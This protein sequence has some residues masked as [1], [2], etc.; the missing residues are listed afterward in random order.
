MKMIIKKMIF[1]SDSSGAEAALRSDTVRDNL[2]D[3]AEDMKT[4]FDAIGY[5]DEAE[6]WEVEE[7]SRGDRIVFNVVNHDPAVKWREVAEGS[8]AKHAQSKNQ[9]GSSRGKSGKRV[10]RKK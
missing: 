5:V 1:K 9:K 6:P 3:I 2:E 8:L 7:S 4:D 10:R